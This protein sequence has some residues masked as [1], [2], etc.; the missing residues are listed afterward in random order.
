MSLFA[1]RTVDSLAMDGKS[2]LRCS[3]SWSRALYQNLNMRLLSMSFPPMPCLASLK[4][5]SEFIS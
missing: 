2:S 5:F 4:I 1:R 3:I